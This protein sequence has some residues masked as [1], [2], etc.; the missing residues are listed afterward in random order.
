MTAAFVVVLVVAVVVVVVVVVVIVVVEGLTNAPTLKEVSEQEARPSQGPATMANQMLNSCGCCIHNRV[1]SNPY[2]LDAWRR[3]QRDVTAL[4]E[5][6]DLG[7]RAG[8]LR[9]WRVYHGVVLE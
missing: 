8:G 6:L 3:A 5:A 4:L 1:G 2:F 9:H 7:V